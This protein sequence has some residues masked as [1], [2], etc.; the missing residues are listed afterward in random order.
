MPL[1]LSE[2]DTQS[3]EL[4]D[5]PDCDRQALE[6]TYQQ[7]S[8]INALISCWRRIYKTRIRPLLSEDSKT[9]SLLDIGFGGGDI[10]QNIAQWATQDGINLEITA[11]ET[12]KRAMEYVQ[13]QNMHEAITFKHCSSTDLLQANRRFDIVISNHLL[14]HLNNEELQKLL[15]EAKQLSIQKVLFNDIERSDIGYLFFNLLARPVFRSSFITHDGLTSIKRSY[16]RQELRRQTPDDWRVE[17]LFPYRLLLSYHHRQTTQ[18][19]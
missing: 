19:G 9:Y 17:S 18:T 15:K 5:D 6:N 13:S 10:T 11:I 3:K 14:H 7:F 4:M 2:R 8:K 16:T 12:D 1:F